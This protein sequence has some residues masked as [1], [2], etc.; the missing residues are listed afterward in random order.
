M[1]TR[2]SYDSDA[3][4]KYDI[5][6]VAQAEENPE[7]AH[8]R[9]EFDDIAGHYDETTEHP[10]GEKES[11][12]DDGMRAAGQAVGL[13]E[14]EE[15][16]NGDLLEKLNKGYTGNGSKKTRVSQMFNS[17]SNA[18]KW[19]AIAGAAAGGSLVGGVL[20]FLALLPLKIEFI[21]K[22]IEARFMAS[23][24]TAVDQETANLFSRY[25]VKDV[26]PSLRAGRCH[27]TIDASCVVVGSDTGLMG[28]TFKAWREGRLE[29]QMALGKP[30][31]VLTAQGNSFFV[32]IDSER[33]GT[34]GQY[35]QLRAGKISIFDLDGTR[36]VSRT[37]IRTSVK[38]ALRD[39]TKWIQLLYRFRVNRLLE[40]K[41]GVKRCIWACSLRDRATNKLAEKK[42]AAQAILLRRILP[43]KQ[44]LILTC[45][46]AGVS[47]SCNPSSLDE[48]AAGETERKTP[49]QKQLEARLAEFAAELGKDSLED[50]IARAEDISKSGL[51]KAIARKAIGSVAG[52]L[53]GDTAGV[54]SGEL[55]ERA[56][57]F[58]GWAILLGNVVY[59]GA[60]IGPLLAH[61]A[62]ALN[63]STA[64]EMYATYATVSAECKSGNCDFAELGSFNQAL[65]TDISG[66]PSKALDFTASPLWEH[67]FASG[68][69]ASTASIFGSLFDG[70]AFAAI[71]NTRYHCDDGSTVPAGQYV[72]PEENFAQDGSEL[73]SNI[74]GAVNSVPGLVPVAHVVTIVGNAP[75]ELLAKAL[76]HV[77]G[78]NLFTDWVG[79]QVAGPLEFVE[80]HLTTSPD[81]DSGARQVDMI[82]AG[83]D[84]TNKASCQTQ[85]GCPNISA[86]AA[87]NIQNQA[88]AEAKTEFD[89]LPL[90]ARMFS[91]DTPY[92]LVG[93]LAIAMPGSF[94]GMVTSSLGDLLLSPFSRLGSLFSSL[95]STNTAFAATSTS[96]PDPFGISQT[97]Y[98]KVPANPDEF[99]EQNCVNGPLGSYNSSTGKLDVSEWLNS[100]DHVTMD[101]VTGEEQLNEA[102][103]CLL[104]LATNQSAG[105]LFDA[106]LLPP[107]TLTQDPPE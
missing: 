34:P 102:N 62:Y 23:S 60:V 25:L 54:A 27:S 84:V 17:K 46:L 50:L 29:R 14:A 18:K 1:A 94:S 22:N 15:K 88:I 41:Y 97:G 24:V 30:S 79:K 39:Q 3:D 99:W 93:R 44:S 64:A 72:C 8:F 57:P 20:I 103:P 98:T 69:S 10:L 63:S 89:M 75:A 101:P 45:V 90:Y 6:H 81:I 51:Q 107:D 104:I 59:L 106:S 21:I 4:E 35:E 28:K 31:I 65:A 52:K 32:S 55:A 66:D 56:I 87:N 61:A 38:K 33:I 48:A 76:E 5:E 82:M 85:L 71:P 47:G 2:T 105:G 96:E 77:P 78:Y 80:R 37:E 83:A 70:K 12:T 53:F 43:E 58:V 49:F 73:A 19:M 86:Q 16:P 11:G 74:G 91:T 40:S 42:L 9:R 26:I 92:S 7:D 100:G 68:S 67:E 36:K 13:R 95:F